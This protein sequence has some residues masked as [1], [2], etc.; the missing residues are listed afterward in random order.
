MTDAREIIAQYLCDRA[1]QGW[2]GVSTF[3]R[4]AYRTAAH[5]MIATLAAAGFRI[6]GPN[7]FD[8]VTLERAAAWHDV[9]ADT[10]EG[11][12]EAIKKDGCWPD[13]AREKIASVHRASAA[14]IRAMEKKDG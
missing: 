8:A 5:G 3:E 10:L 9:Q 13:R 12:C 1:G 2:S 7:E 14:A 6:L 4:A 11:Q